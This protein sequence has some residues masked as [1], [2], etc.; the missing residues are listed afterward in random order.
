MDDPSRI[1][2]LLPCR[3]EAA[4]IG[5]VVRAFRAALPTAEIHVCDNAS[6]DSTA[7]V[8]GDAGAR[9]HA[10]ARPGKAAAVRRL[11]QEVDAD[12]YVLADGDGTYDAAAAPVLVARLLDDGLDHVV[13]CRVA[14]RGTSPFPR[15]HAFGNRLI[16]ALARLCFGGNFRDVESG[17]RAMSRRFALSLPV[18]SE[19]FGLE[20]D[21]VVHALESGALSAEIDVAYGERVAGTESKLRTLRDGSHVILTLLA[22]FRETRPRRFYAAAAAAVLMLAGVAA[23]FGGTARPAVLLATAAAG[24]GVAGL[25]LERRSAVARQARRAALLAADRKR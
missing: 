16:C 23:A 25:L 6:T 15:G 8:A 14:A 24:L 18:R 22:R 21:I 19:G 5:D 4:A 17:F 11:L 9:V 2:V 12:I 1:A 20:P 13:G 7:A 3:D 10:E